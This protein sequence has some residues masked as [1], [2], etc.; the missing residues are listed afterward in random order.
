MDCLG[1]KVIRLVRAKQATKRKSSLDTLIEVVQKELL[2]VNGQTNSNS[3]PSSSPPSPP[4]C[5]TRSTTTTT[6]SSKQSQAQTRSSLI[7]T[8]LPSSSLTSQSNSSLKNT[9]KRLNSNFNHTKHIP[10]N[11][12][13][14]RSGNHDDFTDNIDLIDDEDLNLHHDEQHSNDPIN[15]SSSS[16]ELE[17]IDEIVRETVDR[18][19]A[20]T[21][22]NNAPFIVNMITGTPGTSAN[23]PPEIKPSTNPNV[24]LDDFPLIQSNIWL[25]FR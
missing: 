18:L 14:T 12:H 1:S 16:S 13:R 5:Q 23:T 15:S 6:T 20:I 11:R 4:N 3:P 10:S 19:V 22:L 17:N 9:R 8:V 7:S 24:S 21:L 2:R 25:F